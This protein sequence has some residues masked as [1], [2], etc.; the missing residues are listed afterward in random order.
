MTGL[1]FL[2]R[3]NQHKHIQDTVLDGEMV[4]FLDF[5]CV[6]ETLCAGD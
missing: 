5:V 6:I 1:T 3:K 4:S 2:H